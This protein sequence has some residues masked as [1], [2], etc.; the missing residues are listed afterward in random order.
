MTAR[1]RRLRARCEVVPKG[2]RVR[3]EVDVRIRYKADGPERLVAS[4]GTCGTVQY[5]S[6]GVPGVR[7]DESSE[8]VEVSPEHLEVLE[9][10]AW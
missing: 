1:S 7:W 10:A 5:V 3:T 8:T 6:E 2:T 9:G 4:A